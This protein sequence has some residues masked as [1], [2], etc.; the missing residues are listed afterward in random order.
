MRGTAKINYLTAGKRTKYVATRTNELVY[1]ARY[2]VEASLSW[3]K[4][5][6][7]FLFCI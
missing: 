5:V 6:F 1:I 4:M 2:N 3:K 7:V